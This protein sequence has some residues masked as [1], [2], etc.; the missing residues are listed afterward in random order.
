[1]KKYWGA[2]IISVAILSAV[3][4][5]NGCSA[6]HGEGIDLASQDACLPLLDAAMQPVFDRLS[7]RASVGDA[8][9]PR[10]LSCQTC[11]FQGSSAAP[12]SAHF[13]DPSFPVAVRGFA[14]VINS[15]PNKIYTKAYDPLHF[16]G[17]GTNNN[18]ALE[19]LKANYLSAA[20]SY[21]ACLS[22]QSVGPTPGNNFDPKIFTTSKTIAANQTT[23]ANIQWNLGTE[24]QTTGVSIPGGV[25]RI[26]IQAI[27]ASPGVLQ[28]RISAPSALGSNT[29]AIQIRNIRVLFNNQLVSL[30]AG[31][32]TWI[33]LNNLAPANNATTGRTTPYRLAQ[34]TGSMYL[35]ADTAVATNTIAIGFGDLSESTAY[36]DFNPTTYARLTAAANNAGATPPLA[37]GERV[38]TRRCQSCHSGANIQGGINLATGANNLQLLKLTAAVLPFVPE[39]SPLHSSVIATDATIMP[40]AAAPTGAT[41]P[42]ERRWI[43]DWILDG[44]Q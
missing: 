23:A 18:A 42:A 17:A 25:F 44:A 35:T 27:T 3:T 24:I 4:I 20:N 39:S 21:K 10:F 9:N 26:T 34:G 31:G 19:P 6:E 5:Q 1:M 16:G 32:S 8:A 36:P 12:G 37:D 28:Y 29:S 41:T 11:H 15:D 38:F 14:N 2:A 13:A 22:Q 33:S 43:R 7:G 40:P 30:D